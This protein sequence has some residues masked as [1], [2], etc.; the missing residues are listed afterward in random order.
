MTAVIYIAVYRSR[1]FVS[2]STLPTLSLS[3]FLSSRTQLASRL[4]QVDNPLEWRHCWLATPTRTPF[5]PL[6][7]PLRAAL[8]FCKRWFFFQKF[9]RTRKVYLFEIARELSSFDDW[10]DP[11]WIDD[12]DCESLLFKDIFVL[13][14]K[15]LCWFE[16]VWY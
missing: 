2:P 13:S 10:F 4:S 7:S 15:I 14:L 1:F 8:R 9:F 16:E 3:L 12:L 11:S 6:R 5:S